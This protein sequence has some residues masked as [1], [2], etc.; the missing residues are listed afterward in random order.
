MHII[1]VGNLLSLRYW[2]VASLAKRAAV[3]FHQAFSHAHQQKHCDYKPRHS[4]AIVNMPD[5]HVI[6]FRVKQAIESSV[7]C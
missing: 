7:G 4:D 2:G 5:E 1:A 6:H 3:K